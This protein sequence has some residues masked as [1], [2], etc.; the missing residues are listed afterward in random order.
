MCSFVTYKTPILVSIEGNIGSGKS[1][2]LN[3]LKT[4]H[5]HLTFI[6]EPV[7]VWSTLLDENGRNLLEIYYDDPKRWSYTFQ[8]CTM[9]SR[10]N[11][12]NDAVTKTQDEN[13]QQRRIFISERCLDTDY[14]TFTKMLYD[15]KCLNKMEFQIYKMLF[16]HYKRISLPLRGI[17]HINTSPEASLD[18]IKTRNRSGEENIPLSYLKSL[19]HYTT[20]W[21][22][23]SS[24]P[25]LTIEDTRSTDG[26]G[27]FLQKLES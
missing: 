14:Q 27:E 2:F 22:K 21:I 12:L 11:N 15:D 10:Y 4:S 16:D 18:R 7:S 26:V 25:V 3:V 23:S 17:I 5:P 20:Q 9:T 6:D 24:L 13:G 1:T 8:T 19:D